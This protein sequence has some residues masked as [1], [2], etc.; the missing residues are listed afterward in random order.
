MKDLLEYPETRELRVYP[1]LR[2]HPGYPD[3]QGPRE[4]RGI[5]GT[6]DPPD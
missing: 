3:T 6:L 1:D 2:G 5:M 4:R